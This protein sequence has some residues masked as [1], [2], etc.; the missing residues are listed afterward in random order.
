MG[1]TMHADSSLNEAFRVLGRK[2]KRLFLCGFVA[3]V[4]C[5][6][7]PTAWSAGCLSAD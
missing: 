2:N 4:V 6:R 1:K 5:L 3:V 7:V